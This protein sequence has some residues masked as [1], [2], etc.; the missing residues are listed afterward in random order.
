MDLILKTEKSEPGCLMSIQRMMNGFH[1][2]NF[3]KPADM[4]KL[5]SVHFDH[6]PV[7]SEMEMFILMVQR[8]GNM[9]KMGSFLLRM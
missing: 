4:K 6:L 9:R 7:W 1:S 3:T 2:L 8:H 5:E